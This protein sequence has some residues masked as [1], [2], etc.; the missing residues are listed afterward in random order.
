[1]LAGIRFR[2]R[3]SERVSIYRKT[4]AITSVR[5]GMLNNTSCYYSMKHI[6]RLNGYC[7]VF[8]TNPS[9][10]TIKPGISKSAPYPHLVFRYFPLCF[11]RVP[12]RLYNGTL[13]RCHC[14]RKVGHAGIR[15]LGG[16]FS[17]SFFPFRGSKL[18]GLQ[19]VKEGDDQIEWEQPSR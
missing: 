6:Q 10:Q 13:K 16:G 4:A 1:M 8:Y 3:N 18:S 2:Q 9:L 5:A 14:W 19:I 11:L 12:V 7:C 15:S 17:Q